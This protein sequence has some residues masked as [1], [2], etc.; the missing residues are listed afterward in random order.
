MHLVLL[1]GPPAV[2]KMAVGRR[3]AARTRY[4]LFHNH[5][6]IEPLLEVFDWGTPPFE[7]LKLEFRR[8]VIEEAVAS[9]VPGLVL[10]L[11]WAFQ[12]PEDTAYVR[13][14]LAPVLDAGGRVDFVELTA[15]E[16]TRVAREGTPERL[17]AKPSKAD[18]AWA[19]AH[20]R[21]AGRT[22]V[23]NTGPEQ[24]FPLRDLPGSR[25]VVVAN[26]HGDADQTA[27]R[28]CE[29]LGL[30]PLPS[31]PSRPGAGSPQSE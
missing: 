12:L 10:T 21:E 24:P 8:R 17:A 29:L 9:G 7:T 25:H 15:T 28:V 11:V 2:G 27:G 5:A 19:R 30:P 13:H 26:D 20:V 1:L 6:T 31:L 18:V 22:H 16:E 3:I 14:L 4:R 23:M